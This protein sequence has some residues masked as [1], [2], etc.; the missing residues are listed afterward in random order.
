[1]KNTKVEIVLNTGF[2]HLDK[3]V[4]D[5]PA[6]FEGFTD[7]L[8][9]QRND[10]RTCLINGDRMVIKSFKGMYWPNRLAYSLFRK[11]KAK[12]SFEISLKLLS[13]SIHVPIPVAFIDCYR[14]GWLTQSYFISLY[15]DHTT[16]S[17]FVNDSRIKEKTLL[18]FSDFT[19]RLHEKM[20]YHGDYSN[21]N[22][23]CNEQLDQVKF[24]LVDLNRVV[25]REVGF[26]RG[27]ENFSK[28]NVSI[29]DLKILV[30]RYAALCNRPADL[31][32]YKVL[33]VRK[34]RA[35]SSRWR[36]MLKSIFY[37]RKD[38][39]RQQSIETKSNTFQNEPIERNQ[40]L[41]QT[42]YAKADR[43]DQ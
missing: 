15:F 42:N 23:L 14:Y 33:Q 12:R 3:F 32:L 16:F 10:I 25:F 43:N 4:R 39:S 41:P 8:Q 31:A 18:S 9:N 1:M 36:K 13:L 11:S 5:V 24:T 21:G 19:Y 26:W 7:I 27:I 37:P 40:L 28:L 22:I 35:Q 34:R 20:I 17:E 30:Q 29:S 38:V 6:C 2:I